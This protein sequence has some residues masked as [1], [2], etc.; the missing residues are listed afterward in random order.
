MTIT[1]RHE[2]E[3]KGCLPGCFTFLASSIGI[4]IILL[5]AIV[6]GYL[7]L[8]GAGAFLII[9][10]E[11]TMSDAIV[12]LGGGG[13]RRLNEA[14]KLYEE[15]YGRIIILTETGEWVE[16]YDYMQSFDIQIQL[17]NNGIP[18][19][20][21]LITDSEVS[22]TFEEAK[23]V[24]QLLERR[25][26]SSAIIVT[27]PYHTKRTSIIFNDVFSGSD[28]QISFDPVNPSWY[29]SKTWF[30]SSDGWKFTSL[31]YIKL[32]AYML[33]LQR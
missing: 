22:S 17:L 23:A 25:Q 13:E 33:G 9:A 2:K 4:G 20:N 16:E 19:G 28:I 32:L 6:F 18:K 12:V 26:F 5:T 7:F 31:E 24:R 30:L 29:N 27:D 15:K 14:L 21:I 3:K 8:R 1:N 11:L 10:D